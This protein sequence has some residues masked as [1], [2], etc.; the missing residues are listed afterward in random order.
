MSGVTAQPVTHSARSLESLGRGVAGG[1]VGGVLFG[2]LMQASGMLPM[3]AMLVGADSALVG[4]VVHLAISAFLG[5][6]FVLLLGR[7]TTSLLPSVAAGLAYGAAWWVL[8]ALTLMPA[9]L[10]GETFV[11]DDMAL[12]SLV[13]H[14][15]FGAVLGT[16]VVLLARRRAR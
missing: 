10:G 4:W 1:L 13:G 16:A 9:R 11:V 15:L 6:L 7:W 5:A 2:I 12:R 3:V 14:L 8:G